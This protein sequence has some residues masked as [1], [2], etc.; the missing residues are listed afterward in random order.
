MT[1]DIFGHFK[2]T[3]GQIYLLQENIIIQIFI[4][5][6]I[7]S[8]NKENIG[9]SKEKNNSTITRDFNSSFSKISKIIKQ[10]NRGDID[11][12]NNAIKLLDL[13]NICRILLQKWQGTHYFQ[14][15]C[16][17]QS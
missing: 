14:V 10:E 11:D 1:R 15:Q 13:I 16:K 17:H 3:N 4:W 6:I 12:L 7:D 8:Q 5:V 2:V 9:K